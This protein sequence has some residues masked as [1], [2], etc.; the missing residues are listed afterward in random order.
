MRKDRR[1][2]NN[3]TPDIHTYN[4]LI[5]GYVSEVCAILDPLCCEG[6]AKMDPLGCEVGASLTL[7]CVQLCL[8]SVGST[9]L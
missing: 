8:C 4:S 6:N 3:I 1:K 7:K 2:T 5:N 9:L